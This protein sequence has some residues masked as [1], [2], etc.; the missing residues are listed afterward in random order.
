MSCNVQLV[1][2]IAISYFICINQSKSGTDSTN[3]D[4]LHFNLSGITS[5][6][7]KLVIL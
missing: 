2:F 5:S 1:P 7:Y 3:I 6:F 4:V